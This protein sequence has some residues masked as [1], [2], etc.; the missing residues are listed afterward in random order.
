[1]S[2]II[3]C[4]TN[5]YDKVYVTKPLISRNSNSEKYVVCMNF[6]DHKSGNIFDTIVEHINNNKHNN[7][8]DIFPDYEVSSELKTTLLSLNIKCGN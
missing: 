8:V 4:L 7:L 1:M 3:A 5:Y 2:Q 6:K